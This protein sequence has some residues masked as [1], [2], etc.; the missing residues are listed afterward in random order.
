MLTNFKIKDIKGNEIDFNQYQGKVVLLVNVASK[1]GLTP[2]YAQLEELYQKYKDK[3]LE[4]IGFPCN[5]FGGQE[6][7]TPEEIVQFCESKYNVSFTLTE[8]INV[9]GSDAHPL[10]NYLASQTSDPTTCMSWN[11]VKFLINKDGTFEGRYA[12][13]QEASSLD[14]KISQ[15]VQ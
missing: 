10:F 11:F 6:P 4:I 5:Q 7:G 12:P 14:A 8:K 9:K 3:G 1:C 13:K 15:L 2:Q